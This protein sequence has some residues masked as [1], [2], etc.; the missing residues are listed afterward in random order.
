VATQGLNI[1]FKIDKGLFPVTEIGDER[2]R[3]RQAHE[4]EKR[5]AEFTRLRLSHNLE[6]KF[7]KI[8]GKIWSATDEGTAV[9][10]S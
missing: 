5:Q 8:N 7:K 4:N 6:Q 3:K 1:I 2:C 9:C 10:L